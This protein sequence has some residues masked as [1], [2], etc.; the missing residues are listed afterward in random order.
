M[1]TRT[2]QSEKQEENDDN[3]CINFQ[4]VSAHTEKDHPHQIRGNK[5]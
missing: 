1:Q 3:S 2:E 5:F 4:Q